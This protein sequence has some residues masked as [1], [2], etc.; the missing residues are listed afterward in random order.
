MAELY[1]FIMF[2][3]LRLMNIGWF[4]KKVVTQTIRNTG[5]TLNCSKSVI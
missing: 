2:T 1:V 3:R 5:I 4:V